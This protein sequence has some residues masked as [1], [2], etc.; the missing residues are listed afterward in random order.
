MKLK[1]AAGI[2]I[3]GLGMILLGSCQKVLSGTGYVYDKSTRKPIDGAMVRAYLDTPSPD[4][5]VMTT[6]SGTDGG[7]YVYTQPYTCTGTCPKVIVEISKTGYNAAIVSSPNNDTT[8][9][10][11]SR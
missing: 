9:L 2:I 1:T 10:Q 3:L 6:Y 7:Y 11:A 8:F 4:A 5:Y